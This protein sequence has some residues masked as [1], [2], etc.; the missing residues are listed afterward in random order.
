MKMM[1]FLPLLFLLLPAV[2][3]LWLGVKGDSWALV[4]V[5]VMV[6]VFTAV[7]AVGLMIKA[8]LDVG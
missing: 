6:L 8:G 7:W 5:W 1:A 3:G 2:A 4:P